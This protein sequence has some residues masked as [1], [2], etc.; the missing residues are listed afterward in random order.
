MNK[1]KEKDLV[2]VRNEEDNKII[3]SNS[4]IDITSLDLYKYLNYQGIN[5][6]NNISSS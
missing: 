6:I 4:K 3:D 2:T 5:D 1:I